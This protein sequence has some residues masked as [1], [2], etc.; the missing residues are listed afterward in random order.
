MNISNESKMVKHKPNSIRTYDT[1]G[2]R[3]RAACLCF[4]SDEEREILLVSSSSTPDKW[5]VPG[6]GVEPEE[7]PGVA[8]MRE[9][10]EEAGVTGRLGRCVGIFENTERKHRTRVY[11]LVVSEELDSWEDKKHME[12]EDGS[13]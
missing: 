7:D 5:V 2:F 1:E 4:R 13:L 3:K 11:V 9:T 6:G 12:T 10:V 8:A